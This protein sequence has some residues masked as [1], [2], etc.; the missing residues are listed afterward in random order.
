MLFEIDLNERTH[1]V[2]V[3]KV[4][5]AGPDGGR[6]RVLIDGAPAPA[7]EL[8]G[9][10]GRDTEAVLRDFGVDEATIAALAAAPE[11]PD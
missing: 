3:E 8:A 7:D 1:K 4:G 10:R 5:A 9:L 11:I 2:A 6:F